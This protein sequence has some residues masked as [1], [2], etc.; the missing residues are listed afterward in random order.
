MVDFSMYGFLRFLKK[1]LRKSRK[2]TGHGESAVV[3]EILCYT[4]EEEEQMALYF[5]IIQNVED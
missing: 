5:G 3:Y 4:P 2:T 1:N